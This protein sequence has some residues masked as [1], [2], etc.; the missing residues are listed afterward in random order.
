MHDPWK[1]AGGSSFDF[2]NW[3][4]RMEAWGRPVPTS[5]AATKLRKTQNFGANPGALRMF[6]YLPPGLELGSALAVVLHGCTQ[7]AAA[8]DFGAG[9]ST[10]ADRYRFALIFPEQQKFNNPNGCFNWF[11]PGD[12]MRGQGEALS[13]SNPGH[14]LFAGIAAPG[15]AARVAAAL[16]TPDAFSGWGLRTLSAGQPRYN[17]M[18][19]HN[20]SVWPHDNAL[21]AIGFAHYGL[22]VEASR[23]LSAIFDAGR[24]QDLAR[25]PELF[26]GF[27]RRPNRRRRLI[28]SPARHKPGLP[29]RSSAYSV[30]VLG[31]N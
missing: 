23:L 22:K 1:P 31:W 4:E 18:S 3:Q 28:R 8:Y 10:L 12:T 25:L 19:Y 24:H 29:P 20:G 7:T 13:T 30:L 2:Q 14:A 9:W 11:L 17:P 16:L 26:C 6:S 15:R 27:N 5:P 21:I